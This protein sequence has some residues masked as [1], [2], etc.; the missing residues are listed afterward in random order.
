M[1]VAQP[2]LFPTLVGLSDAVGSRLAD[3][4]ERC[5]VVCRLCDQRHIMCRC[6]M[7]LVRKTVWVGKM[8]V[9]TS[10][11]SRFLIHQFHECIHTAADMFRHGD[12]D[13]IGGFEHHTVQTI[14]HGQVF[15]QP[16]TDIGTALF[17]AINSICREGYFLGKT[18]MFN[19]DQRSENLGDTGRI[20]CCIHVFGIQES[21]AVEIHHHGRFCP[22]GRSLWPVGSGVGLNRLE[23]GI[24]LQTFRFRGFF[25][26]FPIHGI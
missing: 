3:L 11:G 24:R 15:S 23:V 18:R 22:D 8:R 6:V 13:F 17:D 9:R 21:P 10:Q 5:I 20:L 19:R 1:M 12:T 26:G 7:I 14:L 25:C 2:S 16:D 4:A